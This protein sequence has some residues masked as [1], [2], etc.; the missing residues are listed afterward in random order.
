MGETCIPRYRMGWLPDYPDMRDYTPETDEVSA[1]MKRLGQTAS[2]KSMLHKTGA[3]GPKQKSL[4]AL[5]DLRPWCSPVRDQQD[6]GSCTA[7]AGAALVEYF[8]RKAF[9]RHEDVS[10]LFLYKVTRTLLHWTGDTGAFLRSTMGALVLFGVPPEEFWAYRT[11]D[12]ENEPPAFCYSFAQNFQALS[13]FRHDPPGTGRE[14]LLSEIKTHIASGLPSMFGFT[15]YGS[16]SQADG[17][18]RIPF[19]GRSE[20]AIGG[21]AVAAVGYDDALEIA[22]SEPDGPRTTG[23]LLIKNSW[24]MAWGEQGYG[25]LPYYYV[26]RG[27]A[28]DFWS[29]LKNEWVDTGVFKR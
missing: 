11:A 3:A 23:A 12:F 1:R 4:P 2:V 28:E 20:K 17:S 5:A 29:I 27:L 7:H 9:G 18:G 14:K 10:R 24:G 8:E 25:W 16:I 6:L 13:Y 26:L 19:P 15:V 22:N 21:H